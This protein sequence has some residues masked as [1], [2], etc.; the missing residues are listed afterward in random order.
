M[1]RWCYDPAMKWFLTR[2]SILWL[3]LALLCAVAVCAGRLDHSPT[4]SQAL[5]FDV[6]D[7]EPCI[8]GLKS[9]MDLLTVKKMFPEGAFNQAYFV[10][11][12]KIPD[13]KQIVV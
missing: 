13:L 1:Y 7:G 11:P 10:I 9:D 3:V 12:L 8:R 5:G 2:L 4:K 6:C